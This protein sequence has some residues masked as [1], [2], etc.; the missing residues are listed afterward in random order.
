MKQIPWR[1]Y[2]WVIVLLSLALGLATEQTRIR[3]FTA[4]QNA[5]AL[6]EQTARGHIDQICAA[7]DR[8]ADIKEFSGIR[9][10]NK[11]Q[12]KISFKTIDIDY[13]FHTDE[14]KFLLAPEW[15]GEFDLMSLPLL[16]IVPQFL[17]AAIFPGWGN[18]PGTKLSRDFYLA[19]GVCQ[20]LGLAVFSILMFSPLILVRLVGS[21]P[22]AGSIL[23][24]AAAIILARYLYFFRLNSDQLDN[25]TLS[26]EGRWNFAAIRQGLQFQLRDFFWL[27][28]AIGLVCAIQVEHNRSRQLSQHEGRA[29]WW[30]RADVALQ[31]ELKLVS[32]LR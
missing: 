12:R 8:E 28:V 27:T 1:E 5:A 21:K 30:Q 10:A 13:V 25:L 11:G 26:A 3:K 29:E 20:A 32:P 17:L 6:S 22:L 7:T 16:V 2:F 9:F 14:R 18:P 19:A 23:L 24:S 31:K 15:L 4:F